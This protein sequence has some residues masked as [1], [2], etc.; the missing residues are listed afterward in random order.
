[1]QLM[2]TNFTNYSEQTTLRLRWSRCPE[3]TQGQFFEGGG[4][5]DFLP[6]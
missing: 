5:S 4:G 3:A 6:Y 2:I 1:M